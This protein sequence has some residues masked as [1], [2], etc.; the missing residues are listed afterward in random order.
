MVILALETATRGGSVALWD[1]GA[2]AAAHGDTTRTQVERLPGALIDWAREHGRA[3]DDVDL[4]AVVTGPGSFT[5]LRV[6][7]AAVQ[8]LALAGDRRV[9]PVPTLDALAAAWLH[10]APG[11]GLVVACLDGQRGDV[12]VAAYDVSPGAS[13]DDM[14]PVLDARVGTPEE[15]AAWLTTSTAGRAGVMVGSG[16]PRYQAVFRARLPQLRLVDPPVALAEA[17]AHL[18]ARDPDRAV[19]PH[20]LRPIYL[21]RPDA[22]VARDRARAAGSPAVAACSIRRVAPGDDLAGVEALQQLTFTN[23][24][25][26][27]AIRWELEHTDVAR[28]YVMHAGDGTLVA[29]C[30][31]WIVFDELHINS[32]A[33][34]PAWRRRGAARR[35]LA[36]LL[37]E[38][39]QA[40]VRAATLEV[41][42]SNAAARALYEGIEFK[43]EGIRRD[44]YQDPREDALILWKRW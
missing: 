39:A 32:L 18:A 31:C 23:P 33:V 30:A 7:I 19:A 27:A 11:G 14:V 20:A 29:Y 28:V 26:A 5:G 9:V 21:R 10:G 35:L 22:E 2:L 43:V 44:Y 25:G 40:G 6:G 3:L 8:G 17:A 15:A 37:H 1:E 42:A 41:R 36:H 16:G 12:F 4:F 34:A 13:V 38:T 24:W